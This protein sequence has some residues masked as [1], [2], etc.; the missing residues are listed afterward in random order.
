MKNFNYD[1]PSATCVKVVN[2]QNTFPIDGLFFQESLGYFSAASSAD[3]VGKDLSQQDLWV[4]L[5]F[6]GMNL[7]KI[8]R[9]TT[10]ILRELY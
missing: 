8:C 3:K 1:T 2:S 7:N 5:L 9:R 4:W 6:S 10:K